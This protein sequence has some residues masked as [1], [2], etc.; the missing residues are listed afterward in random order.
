MNY[1]DVKTHK[2]HR[3]ITEDHVASLRDHVKLA[4]DIQNNQS[5]AALNGYGHGEVNFKWFNGKVHESWIDKLQTDIYRSPNKKP[6]DSKTA[7]LLEF[8]RWVEK[9]VYGED[10]CRLQACG[11]AK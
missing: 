5:V 10:E 4:L 8:H 9:K 2:D 1:L 11:M 7:S 3:L 6:K